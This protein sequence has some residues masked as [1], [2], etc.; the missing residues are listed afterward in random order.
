MRSR[1][2]ISVF[3]IMIAVCSLSIGGC[4]WNDSESGENITKSNI[5]NIIYD[6]GGSS[7]VEGYG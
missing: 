2:T 1:V 4:S 7:T 6:L 3:S 5:N